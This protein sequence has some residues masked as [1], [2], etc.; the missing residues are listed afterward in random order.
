MDA[1]S[2]G[3]TAQTT[4]PARCRSGP[5][6]IMMLPHKVLDDGSKILTTSGEKLDAQPGRERRRPD[7]STGLHRG[8]APLDK[9]RAMPHQVD[10]SY[11]KILRVHNT[12]TVG[13]PP[14]FDPAGPAASTYLP[15]SEEHSGL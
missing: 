8:D 12:A 4:P 10:Q 2:R 15:L 13:F 1:D 9:G 14:T 5:S 11:R 3:I 6:A 7:R